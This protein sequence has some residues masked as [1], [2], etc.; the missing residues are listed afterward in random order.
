MA[1]KLW[2]NLSKPL[3][4]DVNRFNVES[5]LERQFNISFKH[6]NTNYIGTGNLNICNYPS[7]YP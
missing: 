3:N 4:D 7:N 6:I 5:L 2:Q 1:S